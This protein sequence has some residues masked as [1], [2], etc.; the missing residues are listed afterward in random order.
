MKSLI[1]T[2][3]LVLMFTGTTF[4]Q[5]PS[6]TDVTSTP[7]PDVGHDYIH[8]PVETVNP[9]NGSLSIR[10]GVPIPPSRGFTLPFH[11]AYDSNGVSYIYSKTGSGTYLGWATTQAVLGLGGA[12]LSRGGWS[13]SSP[14][15]SVQKTLFY[16]LND[17]QQYVTCDALTDY[18]FQDADGN[19]HN[20]GLSYFGGTGGQNSA[21]NSAQD[22][23]RVTTAGEGPILATTSSTWTGSVNAVTVTDADGTVYQFPSHF[24]QPEAGICS[25]GCQPATWLP[26]TITDRN[27]NGLS[28][29]TG[30]NGSFPVTY[31]DSIGRTA[32]NISGLGSVSVSGSNP[33]QVYWTSVT[34][35]YTVHMN[36][37]GGQRM[38]TMQGSQ[39]NIS[40]VSAIVLPNGQQYSFQYDPTYGTV[41]KIT[42]PTGG[43]VRTCGP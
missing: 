37:I 4:A 35:N 11:F 26:S 39:Q 6:R 36:Y 21:C 33:Y 43:Y 25:G 2:I 32:L 1:A 10:I 14:M 20:L 28:I 22:E 17:Q 5:L 41:S 27:G 8:A 12:T 40:P 15:M 24:P 13:F 16:E 30:S 23:E 38:C 19:R 42:Y 34:P 7:V 3:S 29:T 18:V 31:G 9:A